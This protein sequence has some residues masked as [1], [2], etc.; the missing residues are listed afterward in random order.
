MFAEAIESILSSQCTPAFVRAVEG[1]A[2][3]QPLVS[4]IAQAGFL[5]LLSPEELG[6]GGAGWSD[7]FDVVALCGVYAVPIPLAQ[8]LAARSLVA[9]PAQLPASVLSFAPAITQTPDGAFLAREV[10]G[11]RV[12]SHVLAADGDRL[13]LLDVASAEKLPTGI[14]ADL[15]ASYRWPADAARSIA[16]KIAP[17]VLQRLGALLHAGLLAGALKRSFDLTLSY[18]N[19]R[20]Q[21]GKSIGKFQAIQHQLSV[22]AE[23][24]AASRMAA[25]AAFASGTPPS[26]AAC[27]VAKAR[28]SEAAQLVASMAHAVHGA[29]GVTEEYD[30]QLYTRRLHAWRVAHGSE[31]YWNRILGAMVVESNHALS[32]DFARAVF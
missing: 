25:Q 21:F 27:A 12:A 3:P 26:L 5:D 8:T 13:V 19:D 23:H 2:D 10:P 28:T 7:F 4:A 9:D 14:H 30:L 16:S 31:A 6:G 18:A 24:V 20:V 32:A 1:G 22:M 15:D 11:G 17:Q 29:I